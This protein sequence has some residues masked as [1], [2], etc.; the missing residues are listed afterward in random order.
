LLERAPKPVWDFADFAPFVPSYGWLRD[1]LA[2]GIQCTDAPP[3][4]HIMAGL[5]TVALALAPKHIVSVNG[6]EHPLHMFFLVVGESGNRKTA[7][8]KR[9]LKTVQPC[10]AQ[11]GIGHRVWYPEASTAEGIIDG[12]ALDPNRLIVVS[13]W[14]EFHNQ[15]NANYSKHTREFINLLYDGSVLQRIKANNVQIKVEKPCVSILGASTPSLVK[16]ST[17]LYDWSAG[18]LARYLIGYMHKPDDREM[19]SAIEH[20]DLVNQ[21]RINYDHFLSD[22]HS[23][24]FS[25]SQEAWDYKVEWEHSKNWLNFRKSLPEHLL[26]SG[27]RISEHLYRLAALYQASMDYP[28]NTVIGEEA[29]ARAIQ[30][31]WW[32]CTGLLDAF[33]IL[34][35]FEANTVTRVMQALRMWGT[36]G[37]T[38]RD[39]LRQTHL[40]GKQ[41]TESVAVLLEREEVDIQKIGFKWI[42]CYKDPLP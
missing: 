28:Y 3:L 37:A 17:S 25:L 33:S 22:S 8:I 13:E 21:L 27:L 6:E 4:Y 40:T 19:T 31:A 35:T 11:Q 16:Q 23:V 20:P 14:T 41:L 9:A 42:Y 5:A 26:P 2:Y 32:C 30:F 24:V 15:G 39:L 18:K 34:P 12:L 7:A 29:M 36:E 10:L 1:Y 38:R